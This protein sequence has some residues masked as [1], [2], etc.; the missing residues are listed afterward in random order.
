[1]NVQETTR[2]LIAN[3]F[4]LNEADI[5]PEKELE[6]DLQLDSLDKIEVAMAAEEE[7]EIELMDDDLGQVKTV[8]EF[9]AVVEKAVAAEREA[10]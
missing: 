4:G 10:T 7:F 3:W 9:Y 5:T 6:R 2:K 1:M 8:G